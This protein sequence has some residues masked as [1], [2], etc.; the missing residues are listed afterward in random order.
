LA[1]INTSRKEEF[2]RTARHVVLGRTVKGVAHEVNNCNAVILSN[3]EYLIG[4]LEEEH[5]SQ[6][7]ID[8]LKAI[9]QYCDQSGRMIRGILDFSREDVLFHEVNINAVI[10]SVLL[11]VEKPL[12]K[13]GIALIKNFDQ[14]IPEINANFSRLQQV[15]LNLIMNSRDAMAKGGCLK[16]STETDGNF[17]EA[18]FEDSGTGIPDDKIKHVFESCFTTK[19]NGNGLGLKICREIVK[20]HSGEIELTNKPENGVKVILKFPVKR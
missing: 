19:I 11:I 6:D 10:E 5:F 7:I 13:Q 9:E 2:I 14:S 20:A 16:I 3:V 8:S 1:D 12:E 15:F 17:I 4:L 18:V